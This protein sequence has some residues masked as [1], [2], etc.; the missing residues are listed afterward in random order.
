MAEYNEV[1][2]LT[3]YVQILN[4][5]T[6]YWVPRYEL[7]IIQCAIDQTWFPF[8][9]QRCQL[10]FQSRLM[11]QNNF[12]LSTLPEDFYKGQA[13]YIESNEWKYIGT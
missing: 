13:K 3:N 2:P 7:S 5:G 1:T 6:C 11:I 9:D 8:D 12:N 10:I 4:N